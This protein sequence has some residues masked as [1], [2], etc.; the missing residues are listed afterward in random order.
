MSVI[1]AFNTEAKL[2]YRL[3]LASDLAVNR[4]ALERSSFIAIF[5]CSSLQSNY[6]LCP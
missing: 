3:V 1:F 4:R 2:F 5:T 6:L